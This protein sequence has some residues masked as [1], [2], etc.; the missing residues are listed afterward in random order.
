MILLMLLYCSWLWLM[1]ILHICCIGGWIVIRVLLVRARCRSC[2]RFSI[3]FSCC[4]RKHIAITLKTIILI[5]IINHHHYYN[6]NNHNYNYN[7]NIKV[8][9]EEI[10]L[11]T[12]TV[13]SFLTHNLIITSST[14]QFSSFKTLYKYLNNWHF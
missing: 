4:W 9:L 10:I 12:S 3:R 14:P 1:Y 5:T 11:I 13:Q 6:R 8:I 2:L 7:K